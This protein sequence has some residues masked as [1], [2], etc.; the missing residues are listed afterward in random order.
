VD[1]TTAYEDRQLRWVWVATAAVLGLLWAM[2]QWFRRTHVA[3]YST[4]GARAPSRLVMQVTEWAALAT[5]GALWGWALG[6][7]GALAFGAQAGHA[8]TLVSFHGALTLLG[9]TAV[10][11]LV[12][13]RPTGTLLTALKDH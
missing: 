4:F 8:L 2:V 13:L 5:V 1:Y 6:V 7:T 9:A 11:V 12:G 3:I 10:V